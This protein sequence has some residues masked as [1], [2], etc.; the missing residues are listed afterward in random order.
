MFL[1]LH[2]Q[3]YDRAPQ[4]IIYLGGALGL[5]AAVII[6]GDSTDAAEDYKHRF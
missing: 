3:M 6:I 4:Y 5:S 1:L 2:L